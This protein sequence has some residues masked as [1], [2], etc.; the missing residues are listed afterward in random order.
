MY[1]Y[2]QAIMAHPFSDGNGRFARLMVHAALARCTELRRPQI[3]LAPA[4]YRR[5]DEFERALTA[6]TNPELA[7]YNAVFL[8]ILE[9]ALILHQAPSS[10]APQ[11]LMISRFRV[12]PAAVVNERR[13]AYIKGADVACERI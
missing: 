10:P 6:P 12:C 5:A 8:S 7:P 1:A 11:S 3:A 4:F 13:L 2:A 9:D